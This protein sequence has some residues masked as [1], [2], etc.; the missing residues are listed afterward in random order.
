MELKVSEGWN[1]E[2]KEQIEFN[3]GI[4][5]CNIYYLNIIY[6]CKLNTKK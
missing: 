1:S 2:E 6:I 3:L 4:N 5:N